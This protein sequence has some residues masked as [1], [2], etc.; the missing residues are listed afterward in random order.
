MR[1]APNNGARVEVE[2]T[3]THPNDG[4]LHPFSLPIPLHLDLYLQEDMLA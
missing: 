1:W 3:V 2:A 4:S